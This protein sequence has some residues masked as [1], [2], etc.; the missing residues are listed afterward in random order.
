MEIDGTSEGF[1]G[2][3]EILGRFIEKPFDL[4]L[5]REGLPLRLILNK[6]QAF[7]SLRNLLQGLA[8][9]GIADQEPQL[10]HAFLWR[11]TR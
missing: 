11:R 5:F 1:Q 3:H 4:R 7:V 9:G 10:L 8:V 6:V 2:F